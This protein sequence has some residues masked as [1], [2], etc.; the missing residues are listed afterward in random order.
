VS[1]LIE[2]T[3]EI[4]PPGDDNGMEDSL[5]PDEIADVGVTYRLPSLDVL[6]YDN[7][8]GENLLNPDQQDAGFHVL[9]VDELTF[10]VLKS[11]NQLRYWD[12]AC[13]LGRVWRLIGFNYS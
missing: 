5:P 3:P 4:I 6:G 8:L 1:C 10:E 12:Y 2:E 7:V 9:E 11:S 13:H